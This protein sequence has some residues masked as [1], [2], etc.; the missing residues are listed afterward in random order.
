MK[1]KNKHFKID[2]VKALKESEAR[3]QKTEEICKFIVL[4]VIAIIGMSLIITQLI[5]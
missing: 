4:I 5:K 1:K 3:K 2:Y